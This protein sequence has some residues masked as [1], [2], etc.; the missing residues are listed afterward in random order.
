MGTARRLLP[1]CLRN[2]T[3][4]RHFQRSNLQK[5]EPC[6]T[7]E[8]PFSAGGLFD[9]LSNPPEKGTM[10]RC[11]FEGW[12]GKPQGSRESEAV[13]TS[14]PFFFFGGGGNYFAFRKGEVA[15]QRKRS[16]KPEDLRYQNPTWFWEELKS[17]PSHQRD[18]SEKDGG[19]PGSEPSGLSL[20]HMD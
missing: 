7:I 18:T 11:H 13:R 17:N 19:R 16:P 8:G 14:F 2:Q 15:T 20:S 6:V 3:E 10:D 9:S 5:D 1:S 4:N 12:I